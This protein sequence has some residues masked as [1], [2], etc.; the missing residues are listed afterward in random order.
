M[1]PILVW[2]HEKGRFSEESYPEVH[3]RFHFSYL[4]PADGLPSSEHVLLLDDSL[5]RERLEDVRNYARNSGS[6]AIP[7]VALASDPVASEEDDLLF[8]V[9]GSTPDEGVLLRT[10]RNAS[11]F[12]ESE[13][14]LK[15]A[16]AATAART[17]ELEELH[18][19]GIALS[20]ERD[21]ERL[22]NLILSKAREITNADAGAI[23]LVE[24]LSENIGPETR[25]EDGLR[26]TGYRSR[27]MLVVPMQNPKGDSI[28]VL[29]LINKKTRRDK[30]L[31]T[32]EDF[33]E[34]VLPFSSFDEQLVR[35]LASQAAVSVDNNNLYLQIEKLFADFVEAAVP[36]TIQYGPLSANLRSI[37]RFGRSLA[38]TNWDPSRWTARRD[39]RSIS[40]YG[41][42]L[43]PASTREDSNQERSFLPAESWPISSD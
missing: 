23:Y 18:A 13:L 8:E 6:L 30:A 2:T 37:S 19:I 32:V 33:Y 34:H 12:L 17:R 38:W 16:Q 42:P 14:Q 10:L 36:F 21:H 11:H 35:S 39:A 26:A 9:L 28:G 15:A 41:T 31:D 25:T 43:P 4:D 24:T 3:R 22:L 20:A 29:Q 27:A 40:S 5:L 1:R 7:V